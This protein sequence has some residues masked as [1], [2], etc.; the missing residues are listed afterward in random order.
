MHR[1]RSVRACP[2]PP[3]EEGCPMRRCFGVIALVLCGV[4]VVLAADTDEAAKTRSERLAVKVTVDWKEK[5]LSDAMGEL[6]SAVKDAKLG[7]LE[8]K[9][10]TGVSI[11]QKIT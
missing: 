7:K 3:F 9:Y 1:P 6:A 8:F 10:G 2:F 11:N 5:T 4:Y